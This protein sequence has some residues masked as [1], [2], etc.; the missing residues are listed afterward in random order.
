MSKV[1]E[2]NTK[3]SQNIQYYKICIKTCLNHQITC[4]NQQNSQHGSMKMQKLKNKIGSDGGSDFPKRIPLNI[5]DCVLRPL[6]VSP[7]PY[8]KQC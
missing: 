6:N 3:K 5:H 7:D 2:S 4:C 1:I 8:K